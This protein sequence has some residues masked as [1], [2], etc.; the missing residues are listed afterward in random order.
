MGPSWWQ[1]KH[2][3]QNAHWALPPQTCGNRWFLSGIAI[4]YRY[5][6]P[7]SENDGLVTDF[8]LGVGLTAGASSVQ[9]P[10]ILI[11]TPPPPRVFTWRQDVRPRARRLLMSVWRG[12][13]IYTDPGDVT[14]TDWWNENKCCICFKQ[15]VH[16]TLLHSSRPQLTP[17]SNGKWHPE[18]LLSNEAAFLAFYTADGMGKS[19]TMIPPNESE[20]AML[21][22]L[23]VCTPTANSN[24]GVSKFAATRTLVSCCQAITREAERPHRG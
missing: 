9:N 24:V 15:H 3:A 13:I 1:S 11:F 16:F 19:R 4:S 8:I 6:S 12:E 22:H 5:E 21:E 18:V 10:A 7:I 17:V 14:N 2:A 23:R 20:N